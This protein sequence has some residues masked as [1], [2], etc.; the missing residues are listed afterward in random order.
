MRKTCPYC[1]TPIEGGCP[2]LLKG[3]EGALGAVETSLGMLCPLDDEEE[4]IEEIDLCEARR[5]SVAEVGTRY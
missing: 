5:V 1:R 4:E 2:A 3:M